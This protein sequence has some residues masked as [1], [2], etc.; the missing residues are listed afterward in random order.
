M[1]STRGSAAIVPTGSVAS[2]LRAAAV[3]A[4]TGMTTVTKVG[5]G[6]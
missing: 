4:S 2:R 3:S 1:I 5:M 6:L